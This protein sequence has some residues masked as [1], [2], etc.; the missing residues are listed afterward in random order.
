MKPKLLFCLIVLFT[1]CS[2]G[3]KV[4]TDNVLYTLGT[5][6]TPP[7]LSNGRVDH[8]RLMDQLI[9]L[10]ANT[11]NYLIWT[12]ETDWQD[13][14]IFLPLA[15]KHKIKVWVSLVPPSESKP[16]AKWSSEPYQMDYEKWATEIAKL[17]KKYPNLVAW[18]IDDFA[19]NLKFYTPDYL[20]KM[21]YNTSS[22]NPALKFIP[23]LYFRQIT[24]EFAKD[25][26]SLIDG[27]LFPYRA[28]SDPAKPNLQNATLVK[29]EIEK[30]RNI[31]SNKIP[32]FLDIYLTAHSRLG[33]STANYVK[34][35]LAEG[36][37]YADGVLIYTH[38]DPGKNE[39]K[40]QVVKNGFSNN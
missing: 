21:R 38:P 2:S 36:K 18:S 29:S 34:D 15:K 1:A 30:V 27:V 11:Y 8:Q 10:H 14:E 7:R 4:L 5:Y 9:D 26:S 6:S 28:E 40:Y 16:I 39:L 12:R 32:V 22:V 37:K 3:K 13:L 19:H 33:A 25:Y 23:C 35:V 24:P 17:S 31:F 20:M